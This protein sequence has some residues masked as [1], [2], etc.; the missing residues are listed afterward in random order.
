MKIGIL[1]EGK[2]PP[3]KRVPLT[4]EQCIEV[5][6]KFPGTEIIVQPVGCAYF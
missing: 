6:K 4:P 3:D 2:I 1:R 5:Q